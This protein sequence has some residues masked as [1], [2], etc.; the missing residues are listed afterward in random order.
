MNES[1]LAEGVD[2]KDWYSVDIS[3]AK[4][5]SVRDGR[6]DEVEGNNKCCFAVNLDKSLHDSTTII[7]F[8]N[9]SIGYYVREFR[10]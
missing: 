4:G 3:M 7:S 6:V 10:L 8:Y 9:D 5:F 2:K 1:E